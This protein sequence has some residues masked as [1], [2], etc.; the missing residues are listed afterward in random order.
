MEYSDTVLRRDHCKFALWILFALL[1]GTTLGIGI[2]FGL[3]YLANCCVTSTGAL[4]VTCIG[5][6]IGII[7]L[8]ISLFKC[9][10]GDCE[11]LYKTDDSEIF[12]YTYR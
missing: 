3:P 6:G 10:Q 2:V 9:V 1:F 8:T 5:I 7:L 11:C 4:V 12:H